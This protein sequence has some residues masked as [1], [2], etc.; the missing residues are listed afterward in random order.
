MSATTLPA[1]D[2]ADLLHRARQ[3]AGARMGF[4]IHLLAFLAVNLMLVAIALSQGRAW[5]VWPLVGWGGGAGGTRPGAG[6]GAG[7]RLP[8]H[9]GPG[10]RP[11]ARPG[12]PS[13]R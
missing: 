9:G 10:T 8:A 12:G 3:R 6:V 4:R 13:V 7:Q 2:D 11:A 1:P 5:F